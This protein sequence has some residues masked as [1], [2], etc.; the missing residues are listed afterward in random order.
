MTGTFV[1]SSIL[2]L[3]AVAFLSHT[4]AETLWS[5]ESDAEEE[6]EKKQNILFGN[7]SIGST[8]FPDESPTTRPSIDKMIALDENALWNKPLNISDYD[9]LHEEGKHDA[10]PENSVDKDP[11]ENVN[12]FLPENPLTESPIHADEQNEPLI[13]DSSNHME[14]IELA[15]SIDSS[16]NLNAHLISSL[17]PS[18]LFLL[19]ND[20]A[21]S[22]VSSPNSEIIASSTSFNCALNDP[23]CKSSQ[24]E[25]LESKFMEEKLKTTF[26][27]FL[28]LPSV[29]SIFKSLKSQDQMVSESSEILMTSTETPT[30]F[31]LPPSPPESP[32][33]LT[34]ENIILIDDKD[35]SVIQTEPS[36]SERPK[37]VK[38]EDNPEE[39]SSERIFPKI[40]TT[41]IIPHIKETA[42]SDIRPLTSTLLTKLSEI[43]STSSVDLLSIE[44]SI[45]PTESD[46]ISSFQI[47]VSHYDDKEIEFE[48]P[49]TD[50][51]KVSR[52]LLDS[53][54]SPFPTPT[55][56]NSK[57]NVPSS[58]DKSTRVITETI[59]EIRLLPS[60]SFQDSRRTSSDIASIEPIVSS[61]SEPTEMSSLVTP[62]SSPGLSTPVLETSQFPV[63]KDSTTSKTPKEEVPPPR[64]T[65]PSCSSLPVCVE[66]TLLDMTWETFCSQAYDFR[67]FLSKSVSHYTRPIFPHHIV[68]DTEV[69]SRNSAI[70]PLQTSP[71]ITISFYVTNDSGEYEERLTEIC[72][73]ILRKWA[74]TAF[75][76]SVIEVRLYNSESQ[77]TPLPLIPE[78][79][80]G[81]VA[82]VSISAVAGV[83][84]CL[85]CI[86]LV[87]MKQKLLQGRNSETA[88]PTA[89]AY[90]LDSLSINASFRR[91][92]NRRS[93]RSYLNHAFNDQE[94]PSHPL[95][96]KTLA[97]CLKSRDLLE[98][99]FKKIPMNM[100]KLDSIPEGA[101]VKNRYSNILPRPESRV[102]LAEPSGDPLK[103]YINANFV[104]GYEGKSAFYIAC[105]APLPEGIED[106]W[107][108]VWEQQSRVIIMLTMFEENGTSRCAVY[109]PQST[110]VSQQPYGDFQ[111]S[112]VKKDVYEF[113][114]ISTLRL[115]DLEKNLFRDI[116]H[117]WFTGWP[118]VGVPK[119]PSSLITFVQQCRPFINCN[120][121]P[122]VIHCSTGTGRT[123]VFLALDICMREYDESR[124]IDILQ[125]VS[126]LRRDRGGA[127]QNKDQYILIHEAMLEYISRVEN[128]THC[129]SICSKN[130]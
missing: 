37:P 48:K 50:Y 113:Y 33:I 14:V 107:R 84:L 76:S 102:V 25:E 126:Q 110:L 31:T 17:N 11:I 29:W 41:P 109:F 70:R 123:G 67:E 6:E 92:R 12:D 99:E 111:V 75:R 56:Y 127:V 108:M 104:K 63:M 61:F 69:C 54:T 78:L 91:R 106:F 15:S 74:P 38:P 20:T 60:S 65:N 5:T 115:L 100:P 114:T 62:V 16:I 18:K 28:S 97:N 32:F 55:W 85:L 119:D 121:G 4:K 59:S 105:Q 53:I 86:L 80:S 118:D 82:A 83:A 58:K 8:L 7:E 95:N 87:I 81:F 88:T 35:E 96:E 36:K 30:S 93:A 40:A 66:I 47:R 42:S 27:P 73:V 128:Q 39:L 89:D 101:H 124:S 71:D 103:C 46:L 98:E 34:S 57:S 52:E 116:A 22:F 26:N 129:P 19:S 130:S 117:L 13:V 122:S 3:S 10:S 44:P 90:S 94:I 51:A 68:L 1:I 49:F 43:S 125:V 9:E 21:P 112:L 79:N 120:S 45:S 64:L 72:G 2:F 77:S 24:T 23:R